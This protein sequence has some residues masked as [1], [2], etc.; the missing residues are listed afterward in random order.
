MASPFSLD[1]GGTMGRDAYAKLV[2]ANMKRYGDRDQAVRK[3]NIQA[4]FGN[5]TAQRYLHSG[6]AKAGGAKAGAGGGKAG[7]AGGKGGGKGGGGGGKAAPNPNANMTTPTSAPGF[8][9]VMTSPSSAPGFLPTQSPTSVENPALG[10]TT[11]PGFW[12]ALRGPTT[13]GGGFSPMRD[14]SLMWQGGTGGG[15]LSGAVP[16]NAVP[17]NAAMSLA[18]VLRGVPPELLGGGV[19]GP[20][21]PGADIGFGM[22]PRGRNPGVILDAGG[23]GRKLRQPQ[24]VPPVSNAPAPFDSLNPEYTY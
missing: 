5:S 1:K 24:F 14:P 16:Q 10:P 2:A 9:P 23:G 18:S 20:G 3:A 11:Q 21:Q 6:G 22:Q 12:D 13:E 15:S 4:G 7:A 19:R 17:P 8:A